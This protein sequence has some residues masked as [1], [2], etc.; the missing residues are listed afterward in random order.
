MR[1]PTPTTFLIYATALGGI[2]LFWTELTV[3]GWCIANSL[4]DAML[5]YDIEEKWRRIERKVREGWVRTDVR[6][7]KMKKK[8]K[9]RRPINFVLNFLSFFV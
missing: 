8:M 4:F 2:S 1:I 3:K 9:D 6:G 7:E 5:V